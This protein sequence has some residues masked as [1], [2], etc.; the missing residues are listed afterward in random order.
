[1]G[2]EWVLDGYGVG[3]GWVW[4]GARLGIMNSDRVRTGSV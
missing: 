3:A 1:M 4:M 2:V